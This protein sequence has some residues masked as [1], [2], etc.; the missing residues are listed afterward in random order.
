MLKGLATGKSDSRENLKVC[1]SSMVVSRINPHRFGFA[2]A[3]KST[4]AV[5]LD[6]ASVRNEHVLVKALVA[7]HEPPHEFRA[8]ATPLIFRK[9][10]QVRIINNEV[11][12]GNRVPESDE[13]RAVPCRDERVR[14][15]KGLEQ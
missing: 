9:D 8:N 5:E 4:I 1:F 3:L 6:G 2:G 15:T 13:P 11:T 14:G 10:E 7:R 12:V